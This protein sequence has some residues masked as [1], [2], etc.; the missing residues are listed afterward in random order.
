MNTSI[1]SGLTISSKKLEVVANFTNGFAQNMIELS[2]GTLIVI[3]Y[4]GDCVEIIERKL[5]DDPQ[6][7]VNAIN[8]LPEDG[9]A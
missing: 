6:E 5:T 1:R 4:G 7:I 2:D 8:S 9:E 3:D